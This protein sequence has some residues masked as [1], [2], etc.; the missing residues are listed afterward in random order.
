MGFQ[1]LAESLLYEEEGPTLDFKRDQYRFDGA[2]DKEKGELLKDILAFAN[3]WRRA[4]AFIYVG[5][6]E[7]KGGRSK[8]VGVACDL[9]DA[10][11]QQFVNSKTNRPIEF[12]YRALEA[13]GRRIALIHV[14]VQQR[15]TY[16]KKDYGDVR[17]ETVYLRRGSSTAIATPDE[18]ARMGV[19]D[20]GRL[21][22]APILGAYLVAGMHQ[23][24]IDKSVTLNVLNL[25]IPTESEFP[26]YGDRHFGAISVLSPGTNAKFYWEYAKWLEMT[27]RFKAVHL[28][29]RNIGGSVARDVKLIIAVKKDAEDIEMCEKGDLPRKPSPTT[30]DSALL[31]PRSIFNKPDV[32]CAATPDGWRVE[33]HLGKIQAMDTAISTDVLCI[34]ASTTAE[35]SM[36]VEI[37][38]DEL[39]CP[40]R[41]QLSL[42]LE[43][44]EKRY[45]VGDFLH[46]GASAKESS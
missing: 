43:V 33:A 36:E 9:D 44:T 37:F 6:E 19:A 21:E 35:V 31:E 40:V 41:E 20:S 46:S 3:T 27:R 45:S 7:I 30:F 15:P 4:D 25:K 18:S 32:R 42:R 16:L 8:V 5:A 10:K 2:S 38:A 22:R 1:E 28:A 34:G 17:K 11:L 13:E 23:E 29:V 24:V 14:P 12:S 39:T 26:R